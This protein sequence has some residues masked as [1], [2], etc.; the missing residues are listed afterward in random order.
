[1]VHRKTA[2]KLRLAVR[3]PKTVFIINFYYCYYSKPS[4]PAARTLAISVPEAARSKDDEKGRP[5]V[6]RHTAGKITPEEQKMERE[7]EDKDPRQR[8]R[9]Q[10]TLG[11]GY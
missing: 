7:R 1:M 10:K 9:E 11:F 3:A 6:P 2:A 4:P 5:H 8:T